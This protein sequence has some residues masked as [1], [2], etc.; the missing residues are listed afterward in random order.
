MADRDMLPG[1]YTASG[2]SREA[3]MPETAF[4]DLSEH[5]QAVLSFVT[6]LVGNRTL[7]EDLTQETFLRATRTGKGHR[8]EA[9]KRSWLCAIA[10][11]LAR[12]HFR[13]SGRN[14]Q[15][16]PDEEV[17]RHIRSDDE[18]AETGVLK[19]EMA[20]CIPEYL[21]R[22]PASQHDV[23]ALHDM[24]DLSHREIAVQLRISEENSRVLLHR[25]RSAL[26]DILEKNCVLSLGSDAVPCERPPRSGVSE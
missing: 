25:G 15:T 17:M 19:K 13:A 22:L 20:D 8:G 14:P 11:N 9:S 12:D 2:W 18:D 24:A 3:V 7:G 1:A 26:R 10:L 16:T 4:D 21:F 6:R 5:R 23:V